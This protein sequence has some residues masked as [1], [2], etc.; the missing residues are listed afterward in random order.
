MILG[1]LEIPNMAVRSLPRSRGWDYAKQGVIEGPPR[2][3]YVAEAETS[4]SM[5]LFLHV[6]FCRPKEILD[7]LMAMGDEHDAQILQSDDGTILGQFIIERIDDKP[8]W[9][10][11]D[12]ALLAVDVDIS[13]SDPGLDTQLART[14]QSP[15]AYIELDDD[16]VDG[17]EYY[18]LDDDYA[19]DVEYIELDESPEDVPVTG[20]VRS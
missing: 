5:S 6:S 20:I 11:P 10:L 4:M 1:W 18:E 16:I 13:L 15:Q 12:G 19:D 8:R 3:Q 9:T 2:A 17:Q 7:A 14:R